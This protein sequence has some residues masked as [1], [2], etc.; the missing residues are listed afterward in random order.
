MSLIWSERRQEDELD[1][2]ATVAITSM[3]HML[4][5]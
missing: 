4:G 2:V 3:R 5:E 1:R